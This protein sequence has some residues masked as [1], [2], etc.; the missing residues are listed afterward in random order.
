LIHPCHDFVSQIVGGGR[1][2]T[3][4]ELPDAHGKNDLLQNDHPKSPGFPMQA[5]KRSESF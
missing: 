5:L 2:C 4:M 3:T 1:K